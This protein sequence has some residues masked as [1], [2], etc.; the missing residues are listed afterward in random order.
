VSANTILQWLKAYR[1]GRLGGGSDRR[2]ER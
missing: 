2:R 1:T